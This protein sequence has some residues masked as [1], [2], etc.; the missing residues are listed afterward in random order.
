LPVLISNGAPA[1]KIPVGSIILRKGDIAYIVV[2]ILADQVCDSEIC[3]L[4]STDDTCFERI[5]DF[6]KAPRVVRD[7]RFALPGI[8]PRMKSNR[9]LVFGAVGTGIL[10]V[11]LG[12]WEAAESGERA[13]EAVS[14][15]TRDVR[16]AIDRSTP[17]KTER[18]VFALG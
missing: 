16:P 5:I 15:V 9:K 8:K 13:M 2:C 18:A 1:I 14:P 11:L 3:P 6:V 4:H 12:G 7:I 10:G 17:T